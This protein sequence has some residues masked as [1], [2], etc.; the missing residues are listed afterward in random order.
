MRAFILSFGIL[1]L[2]NLTQGQDKRYYFY[3]DKDS[4]TIGV[5]DDQGKIILKPEQ[6][7]FG[8]DENEPIQQATLDFPQF[9]ID[10]EFRKPQMEDPNAPAIPYGRVFNR[11]GEFL[12]Y[13]QF[14]DNGADYFVEGYRRFVEQGKIGFADALGNKVIPA[15]WGF[16]NPFEYGYALVYEGKMRKMYDQSGEHWTVVAA[17]EN[18]K[19]HLINTNGALVAPLT[20]S[21]NPKD[22]FFEGQYYPYPFHYTKVEKALLA[23]LNQDLVGISLLFQLRTYQY[24][25][26]AV[27]LEITE[28]PHAFSSE[29]TISAY[30][31]QKSIFDAQLYIDAKT[32]DAYLRNYDN[33]KIPLK[34]AIIKRIEEDL[35]REAEYLNPETRKLAE[36]E[37]MRLKK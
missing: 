5:R 18:V 27:Q 37:L 4:T 2:S 1:L 9:P 21:T 22:Y 8:I 20:N 14:F 10:D 6:Y 33:E 23:Q 35:Q 30:Q 13:P 25:Y 26:A 12:Y 3:G 32:H 16:A 34:Q 28:R 7:T 19:R 17:E 31:D 11:K 24:L 15:E 29:Y 36:E